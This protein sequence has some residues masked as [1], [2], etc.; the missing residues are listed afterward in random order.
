MVARW[1]GEG[2]DRGCEYSGVAECPGVGLCASLVACSIRTVLARWCFRIVLG[3][4]VLYRGEAES[5]V[6]DNQG[7]SFY[8]LCC[9]RCLSKLLSSTYGRRHKF[10][11]FR[12]DGHM[13]LMCR[14]DTRAMVVR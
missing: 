8:L 2:M 9:Y 12:G 1:G 6:T 11:F 13:A 10:G 3:G 4:R 5:K 7:V 14:R